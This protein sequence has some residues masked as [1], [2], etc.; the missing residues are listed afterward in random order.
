M[1]RARIRKEQILEDAEYPVNSHVDVGYTTEGNMCGPKVG[2]CLFV[3]NLRTSTIREI[4]AYD[5]FKTVNSIY[6]AKYTEILGLFVNSQ[7]RDSVTKFLK[8]YGLF[9]IENRQ[10][11]ICRVSGTVQE[12]E[13]SWN[14]EEKLAIPI[15]EFMTNWFEAGRVFISNSIYEN[16]GELVE[17]HGQKIWVSGDLEGYSKVD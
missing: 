11:V 13:H 12:D 16:R 15:S 5:T 3:G 14:V 4:L 1:I 8:A 7:E 2:E 9:E 17:H 6:K 10:Y